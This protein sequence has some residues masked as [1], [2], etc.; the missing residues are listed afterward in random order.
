MTG[1]ADAGNAAVLTSWK[2]IAHYLGKGVRTVQRWEQDFDLPVRRPHGFN[3]R[4]ILA[5]PSDLDAWVATRCSL[6]GRHREQAAVLNVRASLS[7]EIETA[8]LLRESQ[9]VLR[10]ELR[11]EVMALQARLSDICR[12]AGVRG[13][14]SSRG[15]RQ[16]MGGSELRSGWTIGV[17]NMVTVRP[18]MARCNGPEGQPVNRGN[19]HEMSATKEDTAGYAEAMGA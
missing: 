6:S 18:S 8:R 5:R 3:K 13:I 1:V 11:S 17:D 2:E 10:E 19:V 7:A 15:V 4:A 12:Q 9:K 14:R 16:T